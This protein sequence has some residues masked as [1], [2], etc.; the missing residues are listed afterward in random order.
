VVVE[1]HL[2]FANK[3]LRDTFDLKIYI[4]ADDDVRLS[5]RI[6]KAMK[7]GE[8][9]GKKFDIFAFLEKYEKY[10]KPAHEKYVDT[11]K[12]Y[13]DIVI[14]NYGFTIEEINVEEH[15]YSDKPALELIMKEI[16]NRALNLA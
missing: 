1:G 13:A 4:D 2:I 3:E 5:R 14:P 6:L 10:V 7:D 9:D 11:T 12:K 16:K 8:K 15:F